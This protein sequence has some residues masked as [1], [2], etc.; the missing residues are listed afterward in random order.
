MQ[1]LPIRTSSSRRLSP[2]LVALLDDYQAAVVRLLEQ[3]PALSAY[4]ELST[5]LDPIRKHASEHAELSVSSAQLVIAHSELVSTLSE[6]TAGRSRAEKLAQAHERLRG[7]VD[8]MRSVASGTP[9]V[10]DSA[11]R[12]PE[13]SISA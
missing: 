2:E 3:W 9:L 10:G 12:P 7:C 11:A 8:A 1:I 4:S 6:R 5:R 13:S